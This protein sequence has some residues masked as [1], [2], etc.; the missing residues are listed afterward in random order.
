MEPCWVS[1]CEREPAKGTEIWV[2]V[3]QGMATDSHDIGY[4]KAELTTS[5]WRLS[6]KP[7]YT[8]IVAWLES[9]RLLSR[10]EVSE[11]SKGGIRF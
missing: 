3:V 10:Q 4:E 5:G 1:L 11:V 2:L 7:E 8:R 9:D 6:A